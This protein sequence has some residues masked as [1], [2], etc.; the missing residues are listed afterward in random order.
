M[1]TTYRMLISHRSKMGAI[2]MQSYLTPCSSASIVNFEHEIA[3]WV[4]PSSDRLV[5]IAKDFFESAKL[6]CGNKIRFCS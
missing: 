6:C 3:G 5:I 2:Y 4:S 1:I